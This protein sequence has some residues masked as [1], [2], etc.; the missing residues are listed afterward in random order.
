[1]ANPGDRSGS[2]LREGT[3]TAV[4]QRYTPGG[5]RPEIRSDSDNT[6]GEKLNF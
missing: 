3:M 2:V 5:I 6:H 4:A 1:V